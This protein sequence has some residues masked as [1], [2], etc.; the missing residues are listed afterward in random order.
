MSNFKYVVYKEND[1]Y[2]S[3]CLNIDISSFGKNIEEAV[4]N[5]V[6]A[7]ELYYEDEMPTDYSLIQEIM[8]GEKNINV[9][10]SV[11]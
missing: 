2:V 6:E 1:Y 5:M 3:Q 8:V 7:I 9:K 4:K 10:T 11:I